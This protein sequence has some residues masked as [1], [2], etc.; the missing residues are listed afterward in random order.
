MGTRGQINV[1]LLSLGLALAAAGCEDS[2]EEAPPARD[3]G[4]DFT[5]QDA[6]S[7]EDAARPTDASRP[8][9]GAPQEDGG[10]EDGGDT[11]GGGS[12]EASKAEA[13]EKDWAEGCYKCAPENNAQL[14]NSCATG[15]RTFDSEQYPNGWRP[16]DDLPALP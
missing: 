6:A 8:D 12:C 9:G 11:A 7:A 5:D 3:G 4:N 14:L 15:W 2:K 1:W 10:D 16:G 13:D